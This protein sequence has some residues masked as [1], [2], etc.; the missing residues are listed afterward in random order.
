VAKLVADL[1]C[2]TPKRDGGAVEEGDSTRGIGGVDS[3]GKFFDETVL[4]RVARVLRSRRRARR[5]MR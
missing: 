5:A 1:R 2:A 3:G 4:K